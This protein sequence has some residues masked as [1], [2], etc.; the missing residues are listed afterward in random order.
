MT[1]PGRTHVSPDIRA[2]AL[3]LNERAEELGRMLFPAARLDAGELVVGSLDGEPGQSLRLTLRGEHRGLW[4]EHATGAGGDMLDLVAAKLCRGERRTAVRWAIGWLGLGGLDGGTR[5]PG[6]SGRPAEGEPSAAE[7]RQRAKGLWLAASPAILDTPVDLYLRG[8]GLDLRALP[9]LPGAL[10]HHPELYTEGRYWPAMVAAVLGAD[11]QICAV[12]RTFLAREAA[13][14]PASAAGAGGRRWG[15]APVGDGGRKAYGPI[16]GGVIPIW[17]GRSGNPLRT[18]PDDDTVAIAEGVEDAL[19]VALACP[20]WRV[21][22]GLSA[23]NLLHLVLPPALR[24]IVVV[25]DNDAPASPAA[26]AV[27][28]AAAHLVGQGRRVRIARA[29]GGAKDF[30]DRLRGAA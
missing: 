19:T 10:R 9:R 13:I 17:R 23:G 4:C 8:R 6:T 7:R 2:V 22:A 25:A 18:A 16:K 11:L 1:S 27:E 28:A 20:E 14:S 24:D 21:L 30:N 15:K 26:R 3:R 5:R 29:G 12:H